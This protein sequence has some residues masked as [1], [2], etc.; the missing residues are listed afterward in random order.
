VLITYNVQMMLNDF[1]RLIRNYYTHHINTFSKPI[2]LKSMFIL[3]CEGV[4]VAEC[5]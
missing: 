3:F 1:S 4:S 2:K 5:D